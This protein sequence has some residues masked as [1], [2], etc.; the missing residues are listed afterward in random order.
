MEMERTMKASQGLK[1]ENY[2]TKN[3]YIVDIYI[4]KMH[5]LLKVQQVF[6]R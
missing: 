4:D 3:T 5:N 1:A 2:I 6:D